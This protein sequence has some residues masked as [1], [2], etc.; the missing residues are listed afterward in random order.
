M[1]LFLTKLK[2]WLDRVIVEMEK[3]EVEMQLGAARSPQWS[4]VRN[5]FLRKNPNCAACG[6]SE[7]LIAHHKLPFFV[8]PELELREDNLLP[9]CEGTVVNCH[10]LFGHCY[11]QWRCYNRD[12]EQDILI[13][14]KL[15]ENALE[16][17]KENGTVFCN[18]RECELELERRVT[19]M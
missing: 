9:L 8:A 15:R 11:K 2:D 14:K 16:Q 6:K 7:N 18:N 19:K 4:K 12:V 3:R 13:I 5:E 10:F 1:I 17:R